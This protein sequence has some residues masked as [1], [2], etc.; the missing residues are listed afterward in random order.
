MFILANGGSDRSIAALAARMEASMQKL[1]SLLLTISIG[2]GIVALADTSMAQTSPAPSKTGTRLITLGTTAGPPPR[3]HRAQSS[4][5]LIVNGTLYVVD[6]GDGVA[7]RLAKVG[8]DV[9]EI[10]A[11]F[12]THH[13][14]DHTAGLGTL[15]SVAWDNQRTTP[16]NVYGPP[17]TEDLVKAAVQYYTISAEIRIADGGRTV[18]IAQLFFGHDVGTGKVYQD[19]NVKVTAVENTHFEFHKGAA[20]GKY[21]SYSYR[22][23]TADR[24]IVFTGD[25]GPSDAVTELA[26]GADLLVSEA[27]S[28]E[29]RM[30]GLLKSG[31]WQAMTP[32]EQAGITRQMTQ[33]H[34]SP[35]VI[36]KMAARAGVKT[37][38][39]THLTYK[40]D[41]DYTPWVNEVKKYFPGQ[42]LV[43]KDL[44]EF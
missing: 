3:A 21:K 25:T 36:G 32:D 13:H 33:G 20:A 27:N 18:P 10:G 1:L 7:R 15:M 16:I 6:A 37:V 8:I 34:L 14:D 30:Q 11:V 23:E 26:R 19:A 39:L 24:V 5:L 41:G 44:T 22:F 43:A 2:I 12:L 9:R 4:N 42:V 17:R 40:P 29:E 31:Q 35:D 38:V 28:V